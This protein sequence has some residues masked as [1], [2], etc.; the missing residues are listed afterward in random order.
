MPRQNRRRV[1]PAR[2]APAGGGERHEQFGGETYAVRSV[3]GA[4]GTKTYRCPG[5]DHEVRPGVPHVVAWPAHHLEATDRRHWH[6][7]CWTARESRAPGVRRSR[8]AP[9]Y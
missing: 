3:T 1:D 2:R 9:R 7:P 4:G 8:S 6:T 5:C